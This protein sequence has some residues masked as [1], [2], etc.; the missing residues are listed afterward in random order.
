MPEATPLFPNGAPERP[1]RARAETPDLDP[2]KLTAIHDMR[3]R[4]DSEEL[5]KMK[6]A[7]RS[8][9]PA[10]LAQIVN[11]RSIEQMQAN[12]LM[13]VAALELLR[14]PDEENG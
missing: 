13:S 9:A 11:D 7:I 5:R 6:D 4:M 14:E 3:E 10:D 2:A 1:Q 12:P 8:Y